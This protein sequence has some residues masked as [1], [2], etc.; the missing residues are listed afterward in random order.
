MDWAIQENFFIGQ[1]TVRITIIDDLFAKYDHLKVY[2]ECK[3]G[4]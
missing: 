3:F 2:I 1:Q 4:V